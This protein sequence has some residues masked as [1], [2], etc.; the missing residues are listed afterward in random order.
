MCRGH[1]VTQR[2]ALNYLS[3]NRHV[4]DQF[5]WHQVISMAAA[6]ANRF[7]PPRAAIESVRR[8]VQLLRAESLI[9]VKLATEL[10]RL[11]WHGN[12]LVVRLPI[13]RAEIESFILAKLIDRQLHS[14]DDLTEGLDDSDVD[15]VVESLKSRE[16]VSLRVVYRDS[17]SIQAIHLR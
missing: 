7:P 2:F 16:I 14:L 3:R 4:P 10:G 12:C 13:S 6:R 15:Q 8:A 11:P 9:E 17:S 5:S 1:G